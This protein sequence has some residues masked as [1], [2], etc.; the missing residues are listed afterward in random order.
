VAFVQSLDKPSPRCVTD[1]KYCTIAEHDNGDHLKYIPLY[2]RPAGALSDEQIKQV[3][4]NLPS[5]HEKAWFIRYAR[6][7]EA[8]H[9]IGGAE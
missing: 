3:F 7:I 9:K 6:A 5:A 1:L 8:A 2:T 4:D